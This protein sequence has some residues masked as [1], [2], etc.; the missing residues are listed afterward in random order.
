MAANGERVAIGI[1]LGTTY[2][3][4]AVWRNDQVEVIVNDQGNRTT[5]SY[6]SF[7]QNQR[8]IGDAA[9]NNASTNPINSVFDAKRLIGRKFSDPMVQSDK[10]LW[11]FKVIADDNDKPIIVVNHNHKEKRFPAEAI[12]SMVLEKMREISEAYL[13]SK[14]KD[15]VITVPAYFNESQRQATKDAGAIAGLNVMR[16]I[17]EPSAA[18]I[19]YG[20]DMKACIRGR[21]N[22]FIFDLGGGTLDVS[23]LTFEME[24]IQVKTIAGD[25]HLGGEDFDNRMVDY[26]VK[27]FQRK[28][29]MDIRGD[30][31]ALRR[32]RFACEKA[33]RTLSCNTLATIELDFL[34]QGIDFYSSITRAKFE[35][36]NKDYFQKCMELVEK[37]VIDSKMDKSNI[38]DVVLVG[39]SSRIPKVRQLLMDFFGRKDLCNRINPDEAVAH[40]AAV[41]ASILSGEFSEKV[42]SL[43]LREVTPLSLGLEKHGGIMETIIPRNT[44]IPTTMD[45]VFTTHFHNQTNILIHVYEGERQT[46]R[47]NNL[48]G[49]FVLEIPPYPRGVP[50]IKVCFQIDE[51]GILHVSVKEKSNRINMKVTIINDK[52]R[53]S[54]AEIERM[55]RENEKNKAEDERYKKK[56]EAK[57]ALEN[58]AYNM[59]NAIN[60]ED[61]S[62]KLSLEDKQKIN[63]AIDLVLK[64]LGINDAAE[65]DDFERY[66]KDLSK[67]FDPIMLKMIKDLSPT[68]NDVTPSTVGNDKMKRWLQILAKHTL[69]AVYSTLTGDIIGFVCTVIGDIL[70]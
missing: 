69:Q 31:R 42:Q 23:L 16:I 3:C 27:E 50:Q 18:A 34:Y 52:G 62:S 8:M 44:M 36:L 66:S 65:Q 54:R 33:K 39:G 67:A 7:T 70:P 28:N 6:V 2:S 19:A 55:V 43:L 51:E 30:P 17:N 5:P 1:D 60:D 47:H 64:W 37:C 12:S 61:I 56:V 20:V 38:H 10:K 46:T 53:L 68:D 32:L 45:H 40:G 63:D 48:L 41:H 14:V 15:A 9:L 22:V 24:D 13:G 21:R 58:Y 57:N 29:K 49:K 26:F 35:E 59:R 4:V 25:T 11:P